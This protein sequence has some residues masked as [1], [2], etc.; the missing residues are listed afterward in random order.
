[1]SSAPFEAFNS[2]IKEL[3]KLFKELPSKTFK[4]K[5]HIGEM[6]QKMVR[7]MNAE[8]YYAINILGPLVW[9]TKEEIYSKNS[10]FFLQR[11]YDIEVQKLCREHK[12]EFDTAIN[13]VEFMKDAFRNASALQQ[14][15]IMNLMI[16]LLK[17]YAQHVQSERAQK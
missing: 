16:T 7:S 11:R 13:T 2:T 3:F 5:L 10:A 17:V 6:Q 15:S 9:Q 4:S 14:D 1:M 12:V 8:P